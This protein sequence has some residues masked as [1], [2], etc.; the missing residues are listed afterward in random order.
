MGACAE[1]ILPSSSTVP[2]PALVSSAGLPVSDDVNN[3]EGA[4]ESESA[5]ENGEEDLRFNF[6]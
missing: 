2:P 3:E 4:T 1:E 6:R 5:E